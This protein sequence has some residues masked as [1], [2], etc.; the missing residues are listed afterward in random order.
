MATT[1]I[2]DV[3]VP[4]VYLTYQ[5]DN[6]PETTAFFDSGVVVRNP[7]LDA[8]LDGGGMSVDIPYWRDLDASVEPNYSTDDP[9]QNASPQKIQAGEQLARKAFLNQGYSSADLTGELAGSDPMQRI[10]NRFGVY[11][12]RQFQRRL[13]ASVVGVLN[14]NVANEGSDMVH[15]VSIADGNAATEANLYGRAVFT[16]GA[17]TMGDQF[18]GIQAI[19]VHSIVAKRMVDNDDIVYVPDSNGNLTMPTYLGKRVIIDDGMPVL[20]GATSGFRYVSVLFGSG[21]IGYGEGTPRVPVEIA[22][23][24]SQGNGGGVETLWERKSWMI[25][26]SGYKFTSTTVTGQSATLAN[27]RLA[28]NWA[29]QIDRKNVPLAFIITNG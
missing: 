28:A 26:P 17:F 4:E 24:A 11:W 20:P 18:E 10:R 9:T 6:S 15:D 25:H 7:V 22:R 16:A 19:A 12:Q 29:R 2:S 3:V 14:A 8:S 21:A 5:A 1:Q 27:L 13:I 23:E